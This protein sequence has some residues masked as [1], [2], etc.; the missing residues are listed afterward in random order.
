MRIK[1]I[2]GFLLIKIE[3]LFILIVMIN[4]DQWQMPNLYR[5]GYKRR[6]DPNFVVICLFNWLT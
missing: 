5:P 3:E 1:N 6:I 4:L 2:T